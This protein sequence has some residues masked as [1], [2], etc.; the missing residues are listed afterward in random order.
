MKATNSPV[1]EAYVI[2][3]DGS[4]TAVPIGFADEKPR[5]RRANPSACPYGAQTASGPGFAGRACYSNGQAAAMPRRG[6]QLGRRALGVL[7]VLIGLPMLILPGPG[8]ALVGLGLL[9]IAMP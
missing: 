4:K 6:L 8:L 5:G 1:S 9:M 7:F 2:E 3:R